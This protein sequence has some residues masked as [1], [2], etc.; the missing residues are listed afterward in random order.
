[1]ARPACNSAY[2]ISEKRSRR[3]G[4]IIDQCENT[5]KVFGPRSEEG[6]IKGFSLGYNT[7]MG[8][9]IFFII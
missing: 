6:T 8:I 2:T 5:G 1:M 9:L 4:R 3:N 7:S